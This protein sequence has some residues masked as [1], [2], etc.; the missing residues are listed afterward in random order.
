M[1]TYSC[2]K[3]VWN[4]KQSYQYS[5]FEFEYFSWQK[6]AVTA[7]TTVNLGPVFTYWC[8][9]YCGPK[10]SFM[11]FYCSWMK[12]YY[13]TWNK[14]INQYSSFEFEC[15]S[16]QKMSGYSVDGSESWTTIW[17]TYWCVEYCVP[18]SSFMAVYCSWMKTYCD[19]HLNRSRALVM[20]SGVHPG[21]EC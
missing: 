6:W 1:S 3:G 9:E 20:L 12:T 5:S 19:T 21:G 13:D 16:W 18:K 17:R 15:F 2:T 10:S 11:T 4:V 8:V 7:S 14:V